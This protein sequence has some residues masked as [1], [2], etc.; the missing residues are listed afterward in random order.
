M[1]L[2]LTTQ[3]SE[4]AFHEAAAPPLVGV[5]FS[6]SPG[7]SPLTPVPNTSLCFLDSRQV[8][9]RL[10]P[11]P[12]SLD[13][14]VLRSGTS[15]RGP[16][17]PPGSGT[18]SNLQPVPAEPG[19]GYRPQGQGVAELKACWPW[20]VEGGSDEDTGFLWGQCLGSA[21]EK[22]IPQRQGL[23]GKVI[24]KWKTHRERARVTP[25]DYKAQDGLGCQAPGG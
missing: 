14:R 24:R 22:P 23:R 3:S 8:P 5:A 10:A 11:D 15:G 19:S 1:G 20:G 6:P 4:G 17:T 2:G 12:P 16:P 13:H 7:I 21:A 25:H 18:T 9:R